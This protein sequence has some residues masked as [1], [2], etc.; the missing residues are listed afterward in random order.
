MEGSSSRSEGRQPPRVEASTKRMPSKDPAPPLPPPNAE[1][2]RSSGDQSPGTMNTRTSWFHHPDPE[3]R[4][5][6]RI[7]SPPARRAP[8]DDMER[9]DAKE[10]WKKPRTICGCSQSTFVIILF[11]VIVIIAAAVGGGVGG[12]VF[13][14]SR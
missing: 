8:D 4:P 9:G 1:A 3:S 2:N 11:F 14:A 13:A 12:S 6:V 7:D 10:G 5:R